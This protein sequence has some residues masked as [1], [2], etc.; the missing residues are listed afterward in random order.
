MRALDDLRV[1]ELGTGVSAPYCARLFSD[2]GAEVIKVEAPGG[3]S[4]RALGPFPGDEP[5]PEESA[6]FHYLNA[7]K[8]GVVVDLDDVAGRDFF[9]S[10]LQGA[11]VLVENAEPAAH[12]RWGV[13]RR[14]LLP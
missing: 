4:S 13:D 9:H 10:L 12:A 8:R 3:D 6:T 11:D 14:R 1:V 2:L 7:G 5:D